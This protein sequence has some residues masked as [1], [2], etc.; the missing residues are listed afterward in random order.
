MIYAIDFD[1]TIVEDKFPAIGELI[2]YAIECCKIL[3][4]RDNEVILWTCRTAEQLEMVLDFLKLKGFVPAI[5]NDD[6]NKMKELF[7]VGRPRKVYA[8]IYIDDH[9]PGLYKNPEAMKKFWKDFYEEL[10]SEKI[11]ENEI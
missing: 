10:T 2:P 6:S 5:V 4:E 11:K 3:Q 9:T 7:P 1:G 8:D